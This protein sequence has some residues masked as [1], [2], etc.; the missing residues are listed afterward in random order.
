[1]TSRTRLALVVTRAGLGVRSARRFVTTV[2][3]GIGGMRERHVPLR[4]L[5]LGWLSRDGVR[6]EFHPCGHLQDVWL[7]SGVAVRPIAICL[8]AGSLLSADSA[9][10]QRIAFHPTEENLRA[11]GPVTMVSRS[12]TTAG[13]VALDRMALRLRRAVRSDS[14]G[15]LDGDINTALGTIMDVAIDARGRIFVLDMAFQTIR[16]FGPDRKF[17]FNIG[18]KGSGPLDFQFAVALWPERADGI[19]VVD[20]VLGAKYLRVGDKGV[21]RLSRVVMPQ[22]NPTGACGAVGVLHTYAPVKV[23][24]SAEYAAISQYNRDG[25]FVRA[26]GDTY[27][28]ATPLVRDIMSEGIIGCMPDGTVTSSLSKLPFVRGYSSVGALKWT[29]RFKDFIIGKESEETDKDKRHSIGVD[30]NN[31]TRSYIRRITPLDS[32]FAAVQ[33]ALMTP[34]SLRDRSLWAQVDTYVVDVQSGRAAYASSRLPLLTAQS[35]ERLVGFEGD[36]FPRVVFLQ[37]PR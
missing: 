8:A 17:L 21:T 10:A 23:G 27:R 26:F 31:P 18:Q 6:N 35:G 7:R 25:M 2:C 20:A 33:V 28:A 22:G 14:I 12:D 4:R 24:S 15:E 5:V 30:P 3:C 11:T 13:I 36:P 29:V 9:R 19:V 37:L 1:M 16:V 32:R 34:K